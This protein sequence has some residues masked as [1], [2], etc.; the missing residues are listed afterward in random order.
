MSD[1]KKVE[2]EDVFRQ[3]NQLISQ[4]QDIDYVVSL[5]DKAY[6]SVFRDV[7]DE[8]DSIADFAEKNKH[9]VT[10]LEKFRD[11]VPH[12]KVEERML[13]FHY[14]SMLFGIN[15]ATKM[16]NAKLKSSQYYA[17]A[18]SIVAFA[19]FLFSE[20]SIQPLM[21]EIFEGFRA[22]PP[23]GWYPAHVVSLIMMPTVLLWLGLTRW[24]L[25]DTGDVHRYIAIASSENQTPFL[26]RIGAAFRSYVIISFVRYAGSL[27]LDHVNSIDAVRQAI[28]ITYDDSPNKS[29]LRMLERII[30]NLNTAVELDTF[31]QELSFWETQA[32]NNVDINI[33]SLSGVVEGISMS[34]LGI[35]V[36]ALIIKMYL[37]IFSMGA[38]LG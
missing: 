16:A 22:P 17:T 35:F 29:N 13:V 31:T 25:R 1:L 19:L 28:A 20:I 30:R 24:L 8:Y 36:G 12:G 21:F 3:Y 23:A 4:G 5:L 18:V 6:D 14:R 15:D 9:D 10:L 38:V 32:K 27:K 11:C 37:W 2:V 34:L 26:S 7:V 33:H